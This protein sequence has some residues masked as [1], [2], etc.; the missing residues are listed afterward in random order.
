MHW[1]RE[2][3]QQCSIF[4][5]DNLANR[6]EGHG[7]LLETAS[8]KYFTKIDSFNFVFICAG[9]IEIDVV[10]VCISCSEDRHGLEM[11]RV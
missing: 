4:C 10:I 1:Q 9:I 3:W 8:G 11:Q 7:G 5:I 2:E 6:N